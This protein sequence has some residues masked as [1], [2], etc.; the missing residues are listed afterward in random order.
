MQLHPTFQNKYIIFNVTLSHSGKRTPGRAETPKWVCQQM[1]E[2][3]HT[4][5]SLMT[6]IYIY[7]FQSIS[8]V[9]CHTSCYHLEFEHLTT[10]YVSSHQLII[11]QAVLKSIT[12]RQH[13]QYNIAASLRWGH[14]SIQNR[15]SKK[16]AHYS[17]LDL[18]RPILLLSFPRYMVSHHDMNTKRLSSAYTSLIGRICCCTE[19]T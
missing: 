4:R 8:P 5:Y 14:V 2:N 3:E 16:L 18:Y 10:A 9:V 19:V 11:R 13:T 17:L 6:Y 7:I 15:T 1:I 12:S